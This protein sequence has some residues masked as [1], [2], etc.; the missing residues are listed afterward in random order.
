MSCSIRVG[1]DIFLVFLQR[2]RYV[3]V[4][5]KGGSEGGRE[6]EARKRGGRSFAFSRRLRIST[7]QTRLSL[8]THSSKTRALCQNRVQVTAA[9]HSTEGQ[10]SHPVATVVSVRVAHYSSSRS[11]EDRAPPSYKEAWSPVAVAIHVENTVCT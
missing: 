3:G 8:A 11:R 7:Y 10:P 2:L 4:S 5:S 9:S 1:R 6:E